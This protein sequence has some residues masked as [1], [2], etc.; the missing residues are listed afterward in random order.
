MESQIDNLL[1]KDQ[2]RLQVNEIE[3]RI[4][5]HNNMMSQRASSKNV[6]WKDSLNE[7]MYRQEIDLLK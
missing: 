7:Q 3:G 2:K 4:R 6:D 1:S 5:F